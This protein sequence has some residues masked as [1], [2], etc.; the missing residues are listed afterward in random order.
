MWQ[1][2]KIPGTEAPA[3]SRP[4]AMSNWLAGAGKT[5][6]LLIGA[7]SCQGSNPAS[8]AGKPV[9]GERCLGE[10]TESNPERAAVL[11]G[12]REDNPTGQKPRHLQPDNRQRDQN[13]HTYAQH[14]PGPTEAP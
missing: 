4:P 6:S 9:P 13:D 1:G 14:K 7:A 11:A 8:M 10:A 3:L 5:T 12:P 2:V